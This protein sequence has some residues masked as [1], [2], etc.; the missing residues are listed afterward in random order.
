MVY[1]LLIKIN[2][3]DNNEGIQFTNF[4]GRSETSED[5]TSINNKKSVE[6]WS[7]S[8]TM[9]SIIKFAT[10]YAWLGT[11]TVQS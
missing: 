10:N 3:T 4:E 5:D 6:N 1:I 11:I 7:I 9:M 8:N 2:F